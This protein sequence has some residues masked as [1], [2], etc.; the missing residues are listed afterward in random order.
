MNPENF[1]LAVRVALAELLLSG[2]TTA[3]D[4]H[5]VYP[6]GLTDG[7][8]I[9][10]AEAS[11]LGIRMHLTRGSM[12]LSEKDGGLPPESVVQDK[13]TILADSE[14]VVRKFHQHGEGA[15]TQ[16]ALAP[17]SPFSVTTDIME[18]TAV[19]AE[20]LN[21][22]LHTHLAETEDENNF[23]LS[24]YN[25]RPVD[26][27]EN[28][29]WMSNRTWLAHGIHF[30][31]DE[32]I[33]LGKAG[34]GIAHCPSSNHLLASGHCLVPELEK[35]GAP[36]GLA[37]DGSASQDCSN[38]MQEIRQA[39]FLQRIN[40]GAANITHFDA[41]RWATE[42]SAACL[43]RGDIGKFAVGKQADIAMFKLDELRFSG[44]GDPLAALVLCGAHK[45]DRVMIAGKWVVEDGQVPGLDIPSL[46]S[47]HH[48]EALKLQGLI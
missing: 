35:A 7:L 19:L 22:R 2:C 38:L 39:F 32:I 8:D 46:I 12:N 34:V 10:V 24:L 29:G 26:Y 27:L 37:V 21:V 3:A 16:V 42:G 48:G 4:H 11:K 9:Q 18:E 33:R 23:C 14:A 47:Q 25:C 6:K 44:A 17:C 40:Y 41:F 45:A 36:V 1:R 31:D 5:Y 15:M 30:N 20:K 43:G 28:V 13:D